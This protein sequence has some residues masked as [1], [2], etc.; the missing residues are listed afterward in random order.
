MY[1]ITANTNER[2]DCLDDMRI[3]KKEF[4]YELPI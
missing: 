1:F 4:V 2:L 3:R